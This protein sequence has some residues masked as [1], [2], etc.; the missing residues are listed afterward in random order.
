MVEVVKSADEMTIKELYRK[1][2][3]FQN[4]GYE[5]VSYQ[6]DLWG[7][8][9]FPF[10]CVILSLLGFGIAANPLKK[11]SLAKNIAIGICATFLYWSFFSFCKSL[12]S[13]E[14]LP[15]F[16]AAWLS[17]FIFLTLSI[18]ALIINID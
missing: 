6:V 5:T 7:K 15:P 18:I 13:A 16:I 14:I 1:I 17:N 9:A 12:G 8:L 2:H 10:V 3:R 11:S 4:E